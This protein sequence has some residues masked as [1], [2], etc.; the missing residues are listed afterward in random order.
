MIKVKERIFLYLVVFITVTILF[1]VGLVIFVVKSGVGRAEIITWDDQNQ[2]G[3]REENEKRLPGVCVNSGLLAEGSDYVSEYYDYCILKT[4]KNGESTIDF[5]IGPC[6]Q[7]YNIVIPP[8][9]YTPTTPNYSIGCKTEVGF[10]SGTYVGDER[11]YKNYVEW[12]SVKLK[13]AFWT[14]ILISSTLIS[15]SIVFVKRKRTAQIKN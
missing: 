10:T 9:G 14:I 5:H 11:K 15:E 7:I 8:D 4:N 1:G 6:W 13:I 2:N 3:I 12:E